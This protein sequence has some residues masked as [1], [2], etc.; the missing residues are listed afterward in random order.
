MLLVVPLY[1]IT[2]RL[3][4]SDLTDLMVVPLDRITWLAWREKETL[5]I[6]FSFLSGGSGSKDQNVRKE[7]EELALRALTLLLLE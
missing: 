7:N 3:V 6:S 5:L 1:W 2:M 4:S